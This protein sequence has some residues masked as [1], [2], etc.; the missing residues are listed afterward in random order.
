M[1]LFLVANMGRLIEYFV[2]Q[3]DQYY[4][5]VWDSKTSGTGGPADSRLANAFADTYYVYGDT[6]YNDVGVRVFEDKAAE[7]AKQGDV[8]GD[9]GEEA[10]KFCQK[11][12]EASGWSNFTSCIK[13]IVS[14]AKKVANTAKT[15]ASTA[16]DVYAR[17]ENVKDNVANIKQAVQAM[18]GASLTDI[19]ANAGTILNNVNSAVSTTTGTVGALSGAASN[20]SNNIQDMGKSVEQQ[21]EL[22]DRRNLGEA[23]NAFDAT[24][25]GQSWDKENK[26]VIKEDQQVVDPD[27]GEVLT[28]SDGKPLTEKVIKS[29]DNFLTGL[30]NTANDIG[31]KSSELNNFA[32]D[33]LMQAGAVTNVVEDFS[34]GGS[35]SINDRRQEKKEEAHQ[36]QVAENLIGKQ[37]ANAQYRQEAQAENE[38]R[39]MEKQLNYEAEKSVQTLENEATLA[40]QQYQQAQDEVNTLYTQ[41]NAMGQEIGE[42][43]SDVAKKK[44][45]AADACANDPSG[46]VCSTAKMA[47]DAAES[48]LDNKNK[49][50]DQAKNDYN[51]AREKAEDAYQNSLKAN[52]NQAQRDY[53][54]AQKQ[55]EEAQKQLDEINSQI[56]DTASAANTAKGEYDEAVADAQA[57]KKAYEQAVAEGKSPEEIENL[58]QAYQDTLT[59]M[60]DKK[61]TADEK[62]K[63][64]QN[65]SQQQ[66]QAE[67]AYNDAYSQASDA[68]DRLASYTNYIEQKNKTDAAKNS[69]TEKQGVAEQTR[70]AYEEATARCQQSGD[71]ADCRLADRLKSNYEL[72]ANEVTTAQQEYDSLK[73]SLGGYEQNY[74][75]TSLDA[76]KNTRQTSEAAMKQ[77]ADDINQYEVSVSRQRTVVEQAATIYTQARNN[78]TPGDQDAL[79]RASQ[80]YETYKEAKALYDEY[81]TKLRQANNNYAKAQ[82]DYQTAESEIARLEKELKGS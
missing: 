49:Q 61:K 13:D 15:V 80:L 47:A 2:G 68:A 45:T 20:I 53:D 7:V 14:T 65:L 60:S 38:R 62:N 74:L 64:Y 78:L 33:G 34:I 81:Q 40:D 31:N 69:L 73:S 21:Q 32:Q 16:Q 56:D 25:K 28:G 30:Q 37:E 9:P 75:Q 41:M 57:A 54:N 58:E 43:E 44:Q 6:N 29:D 39:N 76:A 51:N 17:Y 42:L 26:E 4:I 71:T 52:Q 55:A 67:D 27:T 12:G 82:S 77:A 3:N 24:L 18:E 59:V 66:K 63:E 10:R 11:D 19:I 70:I 46:S 79:L 48:A 36:Q 22:Q 1:G 5:G 72:A 50:L 35:K 8:T 23:T